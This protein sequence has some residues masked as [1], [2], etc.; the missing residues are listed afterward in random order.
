VR[1]FRAVFCK[2]L[3]QKKRK[4][5]KHHKSTATTFDCCCVPAA[6]LLPAPDPRHRLAYR[7]CA[8]MLRAHLASRR[9]AWRLTQSRSHGGP[10]DAAKGPLVPLVF[11]RRD[12]SRV[13][14]DAHAGDNLLRVAQAHGI[15]LEG[16]C[17]GSV[18]CST[19]HVILEPSVH[20]ALPA[21]SEDEEDMLD[22]AFGLTQTSRLGCQV[23][24]T[25]DMKGAVVTLPK[26]TRNFAVD[27]FVPKPH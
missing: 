4:E 20:D 22:L 27:G 23:K 14:V 16:A 12:G 25:E 1:A 8:T 6:C 18:A 26:A 17:E 11:I 10:P 21:P 24:V 15:E 13:D 19:C 9:L 5:K 2:D 7:P 3:L